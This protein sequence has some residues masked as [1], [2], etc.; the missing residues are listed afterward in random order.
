MH[1]DYIILD[2]SA[3]MHSQWSYALD[4]VNAY[5]RKLAK[6]KVN[7][8]V[9]FITFHNDVVDINQRKSVNHWFAMLEG[10]DFLPDGST[11]LNDAIVASIT[12]AKRDEPKTATLLFVTDGDDTSST[13]T[14]TEAKDLIAEAQALG[15]QVIFIGA[16]FDPREQARR[17][18]VS[19]QQFIEVNPK[20]L[21][22]AL[23]ETAEARAKHVQNG[24]AIAYSPEQ[25]LL[26]GGP[27]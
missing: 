20:R 27:A 10:K 21:R 15:W 25:K 19:E 11:P 9:T 2:R 4:G 12:L 18:G 5:V 22:N 14:E 23:Y 17:Y 6:E 3:S 16:G 7:S 13:H 8:L 1:R 24:T 26:L